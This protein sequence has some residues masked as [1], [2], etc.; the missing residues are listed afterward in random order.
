MTLNRLTAWLIVIVWTAS[1]C[2]PSDKPSRQVSTPLPP[3][4]PAFFSDSLPTPTAHVV[5]TIVAS[6]D[7]TSTPEAPFEG[8]LGLQATLQMPLDELNPNNNVDRY[9]AW[10]MLGSFTDAN[11][12][13]RGAWWFV[14]DGRAD[15]YEA[16]AVILFTEGST[17]LDVVRA[18]AARFLWYCGGAATACAGP[19]LLNFLAYF[20][21]WREPW[22]APG[23][24]THIAAQKYAALAREI[25]QQQPGLL[26]QWIPGADRYVHNTTSLY[27]AAPVDWT[28][29]PF[30]FANVHPSWDAYLRERLRRGPNGSN[31]L[32]VLTLG[33]ADQVCRTRLVCADMTQPRP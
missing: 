25:V 12:P 17:N 16:L 26:T 3:S 29:T 9:R 20:Q 2:A 32:W 8:G 22:R 33:E 24:V 31:H 15:L 27:A 13:Y 11:G 23:G 5:V 4:R 30:H 28:S 10:E 1:A 18:I 21:P 19:A 7:V 6:G 14:D